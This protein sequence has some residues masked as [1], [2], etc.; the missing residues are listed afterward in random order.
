LF[1]SSCGGSGGGGGDEKTEPEK[2]YSESMTLTGNLPLHEVHNKKAFVL[3]AETGTESGV[4][5]EELISG[6]LIDGSNKNVSYVLNS[7]EFSKKEATTSA[8]AIVSG[9]A[10]AVL[11]IFKLWKKGKEDINE[12]GN[13]LKMIDTK[14]PKNG[15]ER[16]NANNFLSLLNILPGT[17][18]EIT[19][20][21]EKYEV[22]L[23]IE[24]SSE[25]KVEEEKENIKQF[26]FLTDAK[27]L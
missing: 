13:T 14:V 2:I 3:Y 21:N 15:F 20:E 8:I 26:A 23:K 5:A 16:K 1:L 18:N 7:F 22:S 11:A 24:E 19:V 6:L 12:D 17:I 25:N 4:S 10:N 27:V 9:T